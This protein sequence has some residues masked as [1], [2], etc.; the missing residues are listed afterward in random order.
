[1]LSK[2][3]ILLSFV[4]RVSRYIR[5]MKTNLMNYLFSVYFVSQPL[6]IWGIFVAHHEVYC[7][8]T[9][10]MYCAGKRIV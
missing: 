6:Y 5:V 9:I 4:D 2:C 3:S 7:I 10:G 8:Y 1:M